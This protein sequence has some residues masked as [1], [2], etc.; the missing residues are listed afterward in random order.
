VLSSSF[1]APQLNDLVK[2]C[3]SIA[4]ISL[5]N[6]SAS[7]KLNLD[8]IGLHHNDL[9]YDCIADLFSR[10]EKGELIQLKTYFEGVPL[11]SVS[12]EALLAHLRRLVFSSVNQSL[13]RL[14]VE[15]DPSLAKI[16]RNTKIAVNTL[17]NFVEVERFG[18]VCIAPTL[19]ETLEH[20]DDIDPKLL[21]SQL[22]GMLKGDERIPEL[23][24]KL[25]LYLRQQSDFKRLVSLVSVANIFRSLFSQAIEAETG[26][27]EST[28]D[29]EL[30]IEEVLGVIRKVSGEVREEML[31]KYV[32]R[33]RTDTE[34]F[35]KYFAVIELHLA[36][37]IIG[38]NGED[39]SFYQ[40]LEA[41]LPGLKFEEYRKTH[42]N[43]LEYMAKTV[44][45][46]VLRALRIRYGS[47][48]ARRKKKPLVDSPQRK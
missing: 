34:T 22:S 4:V 6:K 17:G 26:D 18:E 33:G 43:I 48:N 11:D 24:C 12:D 32:G 40:A 38:E 44:R 21:E 41:L 10:N 14:F 27:Y 1:S 36:D 7:G 23:L 28:A 9:G 45:K 25:S 20:L 42:K 47:F 29:R 5:W 8:L 3:H 35:A 2:L 13:F 31:P 39:P 19:C 15:V 16:L 37:T 30:L 46:R